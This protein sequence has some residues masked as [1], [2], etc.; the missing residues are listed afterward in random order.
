MN[1][2]GLL[3]H[4]CCAPCSTHVV[5]KLMGSYD[6][7]GFFYN[8]NIHPRDE[9]VHRLETARGYAGKIGVEL[10]EGEYDVERWMEATRGYENEPEGGARCPICYRLRLEETAKRAKAGGYDY[11]ATTLTISPHKKAAVINPIGMEMAEKYGVNFHGEDFKKKDGFG[12]SV[13]MSKEHGLY[14]QEYCGCVYSR[15]ERPK[16]LSRGSRR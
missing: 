3:L 4:I 1:K 7:T 2:P 13:E 12:H 11:F 6:V 16:R 9:Y 15:E 8:P 14:R 10:L 5:E